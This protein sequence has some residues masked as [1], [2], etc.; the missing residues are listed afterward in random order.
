V[1]A[2]LQSARRDPARAFEIALASAPRGEEPLRVIPDMPGGEIA[3]DI[4]APAD[5]GP[6][7]VPPLDTLA[8]DAAFLRALGR[9]RAPILDGLLDGLRDFYR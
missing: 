3:G 1:V 5:L 8:H 9:D 4:R 6:V 7:V 2:T